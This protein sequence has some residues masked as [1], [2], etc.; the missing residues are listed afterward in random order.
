M[1]CDIHCYVEFKSATNKHWQSFGERINPGR[2]YD[3]F[4][5]LANVRSY[6]SDVAMFSPRGFPENPGFM[7]RHDYFLWVGDQDAHNQVNKKNVKSYLQ[8]FPNLLTI[9]RDGQIVAIANPAWH[10][11]S[12]L[13]FEELEQVT[14]RADKDNV[15]LEWLALLAAMRELRNHGQDVRLV[16]WFDG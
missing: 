1:G 6:G 10:S 16:F 7:S 2:N 5:L 12:W 13:T 8:T 14:D 15:W 9:K 11:A 4:G 3:L